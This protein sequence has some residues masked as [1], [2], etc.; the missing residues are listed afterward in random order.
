[1]GI[2][3]A[4]MLL[5]ASALA[6][7]HIT[8]LNEIQSLLNGAKDVIYTIIM[9]LLGLAAIISLGKLAIDLYSDSKEKAPATIGWIAATL[10][11]MLLAYAIK[12]WL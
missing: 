7:D 2:L 4:G 9:T 3:S 11:V 8:F 1:M 10:G 12:N 5:P 6:Q